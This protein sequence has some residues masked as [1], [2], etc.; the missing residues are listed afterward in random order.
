MNFVRAS[1]KFFFIFS[2]IIGIALIFLNK[3]VGVLFFAALG[4]G[5]S[6]IFVFWGIEKRKI[7]DKPFR[8][9]D[10]FKNSKMHEQSGTQLIVEG[11][12]SLVCSFGLVYMFID[13]IKTLL[14]V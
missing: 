6:P 11:I 7:Q 12:F 9:S 4:F 2:P 10:L 14:G 5:C 1:L 3:A 13:D 8:F